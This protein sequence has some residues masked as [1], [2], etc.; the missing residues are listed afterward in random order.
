MVR[1]A[2]HCPNGH[3][4]T[5]GDMLVCYQTCLG[6][7]GG[8][9]AWTCRTCD[10]T[11]YGPPLTRIAALE[12]PAPVRISTGVAHGATKPARNCDRLSRL[13]NSVYCRTPG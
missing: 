4:L 1:P 11:V 6:H 5:P 13:S 7:G 9:T 12:G 8:H 10:A 2:T 3:T